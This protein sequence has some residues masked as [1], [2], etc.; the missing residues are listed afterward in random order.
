MH[1]DQVGIPAKSGE[2]FDLVTGEVRLTA[3]YLRFAIWLTYLAEFRDLHQ[4]TS[5]SSWISSADARKLLR[6]VSRIPGMA[7]LWLVE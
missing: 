1:G 4:A 6:L 7:F 5:Q 3:A 2:A